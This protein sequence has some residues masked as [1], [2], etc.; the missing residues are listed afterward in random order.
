MVNASEF[1]EPGQFL[2]PDE[3]YVPECQPKLAERGSYR[4][5]VRPTISP[6]SLLL[7]FE[8]SMS[9]ASTDNSKQFQVNK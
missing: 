9:E 7:I 4:C 3:L 1:D 2:S 5:R 6:D 8:A